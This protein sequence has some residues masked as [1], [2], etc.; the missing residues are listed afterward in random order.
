MQ[1]QWGETDSQTDR[2]KDGLA[3]LIYLVQ[4]IYAGNVDSATLYAVHQIIHI[5]VLLQVDVCIVYPVL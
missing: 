4:D 5:T 1:V 2:Q 3:D